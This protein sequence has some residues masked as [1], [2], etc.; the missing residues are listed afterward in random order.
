MELDQGLRTLPHESGGTL[1]TIENTEI[2]EEVLVP[3]CV[4]VDGIALVHRGINPGVTESVTER[5]SFE[6]VR[7]T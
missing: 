6:A 5:G 7:A 1:L 2:G 4:C 3:R